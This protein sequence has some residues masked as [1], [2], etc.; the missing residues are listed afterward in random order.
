MIFIIGENSRLGQVLNNNQNSVIINRDVY[1]D[2]YKNDA[3]KK[4][5]LFFK[6][7][8]CENSIIYVV[9]GVLNPKLPK[10]E[11]V[12][13]N[14]LLAKNIIKGVSK[15]GIKVVTFGTIMEEL[16]ADE[17]PYVHSK[18]L[19]GEF[20][21]DLSNINHNILH[22]RMHTLYGGNN[23][24]VPHMFLGQI[25]EAIKNNSVFKM[26]SGEQIREYHHIDDESVAI[27]S[28]VGS[29]AYGVVDL[30]HGR[31]EKLKAIAEH[32][33]N[34]L[35]LHDLLSI[36]NKA[37]SIHENYNVVFARTEEVSNLEFRDTL[38]GIYSYIRHCIKSNG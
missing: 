25:Y 13:I 32:I 36:E 34:Q 24:P 4:I 19:L 38:K 22:V 16:M 20:V 28:I 7:W 6:Q 15:V 5:S 12:K 3:E 11:H 29:G 35:E 1:Q 8:S 18:Y 9:A 2:W 30:S 17:N 23:L 37:G 21:K 33:F 14:F 10:K 27:N 31:P 26:S